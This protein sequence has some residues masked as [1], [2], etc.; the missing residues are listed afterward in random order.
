MRTADD[1]LTAVAYGP[2]VVDTVVRNV[3]VRVAEQT[4]YPFRESVTMTVAPERP[5]R[6]PL[7]VRIPAWASGAQLAVN[8]QAFAGVVKPGSFVAIDREWHSGDQ[9]EL[10]LP[11]TPRVS[12]W[13]NRSVAVERGP[14]VFSYSPGEHWVKLR[15]RGMTA[16]WQVFPDRG[17]NYALAVTEQN[18]AAL[19]VT[20]GAIGAVPFA[21]GSKAVVLK[22]P[23]S[24]LDAWRAEDGVAAAPP[25]LPSK[26][27]A[28]IQ[29]IDL[30]PYGSARLRITAFPALQG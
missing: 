1:G 28:L 25:K 6:F 26:G 8:G 14:L 4:E 10:R 11:M 19:A 2:C 5:L 12:R 3:K 23:A 18:A 29:T 22:A 15:D 21:G 16:D 13:F 7:Q 27:V 20:E 9:V 24:Q 30:V 17:W